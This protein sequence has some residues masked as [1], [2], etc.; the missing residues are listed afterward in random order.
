MI[1]HNIRIIKVSPSGNTEIL[2][3]ET[4]PEYLARRSMPNLPASF[5]GGHFELEVVEKKPDKRFRGGYR[6]R[7]TRFN[8]E[9]G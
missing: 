7:V 8:N 5:P 2:C 3:L 9:R 1:S 4:T 6:K